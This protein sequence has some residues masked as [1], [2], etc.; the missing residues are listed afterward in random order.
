MNVCNEWDIE[1][2]QTSISSL[3]TSKEI[4]LT[5]EIIFCPVTNVDNADLFHR[6]RW[7]GK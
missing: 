2:N 4:T 5:G 7:N 3:R 6:A 1:H